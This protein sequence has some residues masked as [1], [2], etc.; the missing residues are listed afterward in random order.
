MKYWVVH[1]LV[2]VAS[3]RLFAGG[4]RPPGLGSGAPGLRIIWNATNQYIVFNDLSYVT[5]WPGWPEK[6][7][8]QV[9]VERNFDIQTITEP[10]L[11]KQ[12][13]LELYPFDE[14]T[15]FFDMGICEWSP[16]YKTSG[17]PRKTWAF[18]ISITNG[19]IILVSRDVYALAR[20]RYG[21]TTNQLFLGKI[22]TN[23]F[24]CANRNLRKVYYRTTEESQATHYFKLPRKVI[25]LDGVTMA[26]NTNKDFA[27]R[28]TVK[29]G[30]F[31]WFDPAVA[32]GLF[33]E[34][35]LKDSKHMRN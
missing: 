15:A 7:P 28:G 14:E 31:D 5:S 20:S 27:V 24:Y 33:C 35:S 3:F 25:D 10:C 26:L 2:V 6:K 23:I 12:N 16:D 8:I 29:A 30:W 19:E 34:L 32:H 9:L 1:F 11:V 4:D 18:S 22:G 17:W 13:E 21:L